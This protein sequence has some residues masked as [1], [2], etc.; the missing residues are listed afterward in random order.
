MCQ[1]KFT[2]IAEWLIKKYQPELGK[3][4]YEQNKFLHRFEISNRLELTL[5]FT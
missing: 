1:L 4:L 3:Y 5:R 2:N